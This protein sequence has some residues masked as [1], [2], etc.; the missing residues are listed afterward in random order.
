[1]SSEDAILARLTAPG[2]PFEVVVED[3][4][5]EQMPVIKNRPRSLRRASHTTRI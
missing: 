2:G 4:L 3:V 5:G 1:M